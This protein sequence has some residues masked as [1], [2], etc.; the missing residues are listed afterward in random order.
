MRELAEDVGDDRVVEQLAGRAQSEATLVGRFS[1][2][3]SADAGEK[4][5]VAV[6]LRALHFFDPDTGV[7]IRRP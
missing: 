6:D 3:T 2:R 4:I 7:A 5:D 1:P